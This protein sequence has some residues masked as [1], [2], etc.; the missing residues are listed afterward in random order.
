MQRAA[1][2]AIRQGCIRGTRLG[3]CF[4][5]EDLHHR[6]EARIDRLDA[7]QVSPD[8]LFRRNLFF[9]NRAGPAPLLKRK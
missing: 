5:G 2:V 1:D 8:Y 7:L 6:I 4:L 3:K 9:A